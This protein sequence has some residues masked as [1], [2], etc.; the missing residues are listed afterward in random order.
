MLWV[1]PFTLVRE[2]NE[3][4]RIFRRSIPTAPKR[5]Q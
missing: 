2:A 3:L 1:N 5:K 4:I